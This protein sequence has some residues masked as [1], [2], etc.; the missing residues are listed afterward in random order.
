MSSQPTK[1][2]SLRWLRASLLAAF[3]LVIGLGGAGVWAKQRLLAAYPAPG[4]RIDAGGFKL[5]IHCTGEGA[6]TV[7]FASGSDPLHFPEFSYQ[8]CGGCLAWV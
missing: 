7:I 6:P 4:Q 2:R 1:R 3:L 5:H 8:G